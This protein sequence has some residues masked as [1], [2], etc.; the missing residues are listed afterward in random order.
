MN[1]TTGKVG[2]RE[3]RTVHVLNRARIY[4]VNLPRR[5]ALRLQKTSTYWSKCRFL[6]D[7]AQ[8]ADYHRNK[9]SRGE[10]KSE[11]SRLLRV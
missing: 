4:R 9:I 2:L 11:I 10:E 1:F 7:F 3:E 8:R 6:E 5:S